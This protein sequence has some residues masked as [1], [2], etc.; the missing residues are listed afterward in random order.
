LAVGQLDRKTRDRLF[1]ELAKN[2]ALVVRLAEHL[3]ALSP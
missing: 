1:I 2:P 3:H